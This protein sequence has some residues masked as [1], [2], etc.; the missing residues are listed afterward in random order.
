MGQEALEIREIAPNRRV[1]K[2]VSKRFWH[3]SKVKMM[4]VYR[5]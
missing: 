2:K 4:T 3:T 1:S 5:W